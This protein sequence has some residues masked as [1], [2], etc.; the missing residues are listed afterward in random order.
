MNPETIE[1]RLRDG[2]RITAAEFDREC[3]AWASRV[4]GQH[5]GPALEALW[6]ATMA[7][8]DIGVRT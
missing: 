2:R 7:Q 5:L 6:Q 4:V 3:T 8:R 1:Y